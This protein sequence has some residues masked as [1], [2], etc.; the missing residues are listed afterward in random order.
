MKKE[1]SIGELFFRYTR[2][3]LSG[4][5]Q[6]ALS[7]WRARYPANEALFLYETDP[8]HTREAIRKIYDLRESVQEKIKANYP[9]PWVPVPVIVY[10][11]FAKFRR[12]AATVLVLFV[13]T[14][15]SLTRADYS[16]QAGSY[17]ANLIDPD[18]V[19][20]AVDDFHRGFRAGA[21]KIKVSE[22]TNGDVDYTTHSDVHADKTKMFEVYTKK[23]N[24]FILHFPDGTRV[25]VNAE[26]TISYPA[27]FSQDT[28]RIELSGE[29][30]FEIS[31]QQKKVY[32]IHSGPFN[33]QTSAA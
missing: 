1:T 3:E 21:Q 14:L 8:E 30:Y 31:D 15:L 12:I 22:K 29:A 28:T 6:K 5:Q 10:K 25:W 23:G 33:V 7:D 16:L 17:E 4:E 19:S 2:R 32:Q 11:G 13:M 24:M 9:A 27:N 20:T 18:K 26:T